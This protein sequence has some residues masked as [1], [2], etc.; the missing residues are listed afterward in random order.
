VRFARRAA[1]AGGRIVPTA[2][3]MPGAGLQKRLGML[4]RAQ[5]GRLSPLRRASAGLACSAIVVV[6]ATAAPSAVP[7]QDVPSPRQ[8]SWSVQ[9][10][11]HFEVFHEN[12]PATRVSEAVQEAEAAYAHLSA[13]LKHDMPRRIPIVLVRRDRDLGPDLAPP[14][15]ATSRQRVVMSLES[16]DRGTGL[17]VH[18]LTHQFAFEIVP[19]TSR[20]DPDLIEGLAEYQRGAWSTEDLRLTRDAVAAGVIPAVTSLVNTDRHWAHAVFDFVSQQYGEEGVRRLLFA[21][22]TRET[23]PQAVPMAFGITIERFD[24]GFRDFAMVRYGRR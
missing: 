18:E 23:L 1:H 7:A 19:A 13:A 2:T 21:L 14:G 20:I 11:D 3:A 5:A 22:R 9:T 8:T 16:F 4:G 15:D 12:I 24:Q 6:C 10:T 17:I